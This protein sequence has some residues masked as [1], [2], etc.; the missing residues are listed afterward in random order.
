MDRKHFNDYDLLR[1]FA[2][3]FVVIWDSVI[4]LYK[5]VFYF[6]FIFGNLEE[7]EFIGKKIQTISKTAWQTLIFSQVQYFSSSAWDSCKT[8]KTKVSICSI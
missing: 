3:L 8:M 7:C 4:L 2:I 1:I 6:F 5:N